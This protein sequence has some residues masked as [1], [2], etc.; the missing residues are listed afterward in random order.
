MNAATS[1]LHVFYVIENDTIPRFS[2]GERWLVG[3]RFQDIPF[4]FPARTAY[5]KH[6]QW[7]RWIA[8]TLK[9]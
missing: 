1:F 9:V 2:L 6:H 8:E 7:Y 3:E 5:T 4:D